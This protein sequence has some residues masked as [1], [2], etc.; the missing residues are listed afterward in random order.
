MSFSLTSGKT[1]GKG[2]GRGSPAP[3]IDE[4][5]FDKQVFNNGATYT[6]NVS[7]ANAGNGSH[8]STISAIGVNDSHRQRSGSSHGVSNYHIG[9]SGTETL[10]EENM[11]LTQQL[12]E[13]QG[14]YNQLLSKF[15]GNHNALR[16]ALDEIKRL[17]QSNDQLKAERR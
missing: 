9:G 6:H 16:R 2:P 7:Y 14:R 4:P 13:L 15:E 17:R 10:S 8:I 12:H 3:I 5:Q 11:R 1:F